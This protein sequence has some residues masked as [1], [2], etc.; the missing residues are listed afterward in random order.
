MHTRPLVPIA[1]TYRRR[2]DPFYARLSFWLF[3]LGLGVGFDIA[4]IMGALT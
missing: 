2:A 4:L 3:L 1:H